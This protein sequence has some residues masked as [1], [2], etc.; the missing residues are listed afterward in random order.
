M[1]T[2]STSL[3][4]GSIVMSPFFPDNGILCLFLCQSYKRP[5]IFIFFKESVFGF[6]VFSIVLSQM[7]LI[8]ALTFISFLLFALDFLLFP[9]FSRWKLG[10]LI[11][12]LFLPLNIYCYKFPFNYCFSCTSHILIY[13]HSCSYQNVF[14]FSLRIFPAKTLVGKGKGLTCTVKVTDR[15]KP[16]CHL[17]FTYLVDN[18]GRDTDKDTAP[19]TALGFGVTVQGGAF[20]LCLAHSTCWQNMSTSKV[21]LRTMRRCGAIHRKQTELSSRQGWEFW[22]LIPWLVSGCRELRGSGG[23]DSGA[24][25]AGC[26]ATGQMMN[27]LFPVCRTKRQDKNSWW[28]WVG[29]PS[30]PISD[31]SNG[32]LRNSSHTSGEDVQPTEGAPHWH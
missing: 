15:P 22:L 21:R 6:I 12:D 8:S 1:I 27:H 14:W 3:Y 11:W 5:N 16:E 24:S 19:Q 9:N 30:L 29:D 2:W 32:D 13:F 7:S 10:L 26:S 31:L 23:E 20:A 18:W 4:A 25:T 17:D 28:E